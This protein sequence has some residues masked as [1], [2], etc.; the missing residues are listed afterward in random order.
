V[1][2][3]G[4]KGNELLR[5]FL[6]GLVI[7]LL[8]SPVV[9]AKELM[10]CT[11]KGFEPYVLQEGKVLNGIDIDIV[12]AILK[13]AR[14]P[15][16][17]EV[18]SWQRLIQKLKDGTCDV[19]FSLFD[20][21][22]RRQFVE[23][24]F[25]VPVHYSTFR[26]FVKQGKKLNF[27]RISDFFGLKVAHNKGFALTIGL[28]QAIADRR[29]QRFEFEN[30]ADALKMLESGKVDAVLDNEARF[31]YYLKKQGKLA[32]IK[33]LSVPFLPYEPAF[34]VISRQSKITDRVKIRDLLEANLKELHLDGTIR[35]ITTRYLN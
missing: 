13:R 22:D 1:G 11:H 12:V 33:G 9:S 32:K 6:V 24:L 7:L 21:Q 23:Y 18:Y 20:T 16:K 15:A 31:R 14:Q 4:R 28:E 25:E 8:A 30:V 29:I 3:E 19:G 17:I 10:F 26:V 2:K 34:M 35:Q 27:N 5:I